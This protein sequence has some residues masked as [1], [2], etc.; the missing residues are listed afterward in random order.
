MMSATAEIRVLPTV[1]LRPP[2]RSY[3]RQEKGWWGSFGGHTNRRRRK[4]RAPNLW[5]S[6]AMAEDYVKGDVMFERLWS[7]AIAPGS[8]TPNVC[9][10]NRS[11][12]PMS[13]ANFI[14]Y[15]QARNGATRVAHPGYLFVP[16]LNGSGYMWELSWYWLGDVWNSRFRLVRYN[17]K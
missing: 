12:F 15:S 1:V 6:F 7:L 9:S 13:C 16:C 8:S 10:P 17:Y 5:S 14:W 4:P 11:P 2:R 3:K